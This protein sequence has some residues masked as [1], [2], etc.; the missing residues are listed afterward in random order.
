MFDWLYFKISVVSELFVLHI[1]D[2]LKWLTGSHDDAAPFEL[3]KGWNPVSYTTVSLVFCINCITWGHLGNVSSNY[4]C[5]LKQFAE[6]MIPH[7][8]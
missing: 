3:R 1:S 5:Q 4:H 6:S 8:Q 2:R 7:E